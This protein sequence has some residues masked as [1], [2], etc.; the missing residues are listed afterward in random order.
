MEKQCRGIFTSAMAA[1]QNDS[2]CEVNR[3]HEALFLVLASQR[4]PH[5][6]QY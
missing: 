5:M 4:V 3:S 2:D 1:S 6:A